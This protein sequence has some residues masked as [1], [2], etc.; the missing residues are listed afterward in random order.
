MEPTKENG[1]PLG[2][3]PGRESER[4]DEVIF[5]AIEKL[6]YEVRLYPDVFAWRVTE[7]L[8]DA[9]YIAR[10]PE[11]RMAEALDRLYEDSGRSATLYRSADGTVGKAAW[12]SRTVHVG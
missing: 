12:Q 1:Y 7:A 11:T 10:D 8:K 5:R 3:P 9:G 2:R 6:P 4:A